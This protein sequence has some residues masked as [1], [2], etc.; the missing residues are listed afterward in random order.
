MR[1]TIRAFKGGGSN[2]HDGFPLMDYN[3]HLGPRF[4]TDVITKGEELVAAE[5]SVQI[6]LYY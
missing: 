3:P 4:C 6:D 2:L 5:E 1:D